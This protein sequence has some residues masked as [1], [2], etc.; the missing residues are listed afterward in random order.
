MIG[1][2]KN[3]QSRISYFIASLIDNYDE[4]LNSLRIPKGVFEKQDKENIR[5]CGNNGSQKCK[6]NRN[7]NLAKLYKSDIKCREGLHS[8]GARIRKLLENCYNSS[9][10]KFKFKLY[11]IPTSNEDTAKQLEALLLNVY[12]LSHGCLPL[13]NKKIEGFKLYFL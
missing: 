1:Q 3:L 12:K 7:N 4:Y 6:G 5:C 8:E 11:L 9:S 2:S 10:G 13:F